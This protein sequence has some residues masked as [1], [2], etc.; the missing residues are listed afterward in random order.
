MP[1]RAKRPCLKTGCPSLVDSGYC[2]DHQQ[3]AAKVYDRWR[4]TPAERGYDH[5]WQRVRLE[6]LKRDC[7]LCQMCLAQQRVTPAKDVDHIQPISVR[8]DLRL[9]L[10]NL[11]SLCRSCHGLKTLTERAPETRCP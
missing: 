2:A 5:D 7:Y 3:H 1:T 11:Q 9:E 10:S 8:P 4:G 6:A